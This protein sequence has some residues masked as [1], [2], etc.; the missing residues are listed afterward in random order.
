MTGFMVYGTIGLAF[1][2]LGILIRVGVWKAWFLKQDLPPIRMRASVYVVFPLGLAFLAAPIINIA[3]SSEMQAANA[4]TAFLGSVAVLGTILALWQPW[5]L[6]PTW[7][8]RLESQYDSDTINALIAEWRKMDRKEW[9]ALIETQQ[10]LDELVGR[11][12][13]SVATTDRRGRPIER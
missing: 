4:A 12:G 2:V 6:K 13:I 7:L 9:G 3:A 1:W 11:A 5:W 8:Q 10:G